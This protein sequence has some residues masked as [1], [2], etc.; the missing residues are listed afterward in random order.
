MELKT[1]SISDFVLSYQFLKA[2]GTPFKEFK[3]FE[4][5]LIDENGTRLKYAE[6]P[7]EKE[8]MTSW[9]KLILNVKRL[10]NRFGIRNQTSQRIISLFL[11]KESHLTQTQTKMI[12]NKILE[13]YYPIIITVD[14]SLIN[15]KLEEAI[16]EEEACYFER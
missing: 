13:K 5:G 3:A 4:L 15:T 2:V 6:T 12:T 8:A 10:M 7:E 11:L 9:D 1:E 16:I 14:E